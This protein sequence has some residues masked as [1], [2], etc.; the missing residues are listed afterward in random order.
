VLITTR[1]RV[2]VACTG[3]LIAAASCYAETQVQTFDTSWTVSPWDFYGEVSSRM[4][5][6]TPYTIWD[7]TLGSLSKVEISTVVSGSRSK[8]SEAL[9]FAYCFYTGGSDRVDYQFDSGFTFTS[10]S[11]ELHWQ[12]T[13]SLTGNALVDWLTYYYVPKGA[14]TGA[15][16]VETNAPTSTYTI[17][18]KTSLTYEYSPFA[19]TL[20]IDVASGVKNQNQAGRAFLSGT[21]SLVKRGLGTLVLD[22]MNTITGSTTVQGG[23]LRLA[24]AAALPTSTISVLA[25]GTLSLAP[26]LATTVGGLKTNAGGRV[27]VGD[28]SITVAKG[29]SAFSLFSALQAG[30]GSG[31]WNGASG[32]TSSA[33]AASS[34]SRTVGWLDNGDGSVTFGYAAAGD[35][36]LDWT[37]DILDVSGMLSSGRFNSGLTAT[38]AEGDFN[39]DGFADIT[40]V[41]D[42]L[43]T[44]LYDDGFYNAPAGTI[45]AVP[46]PSV[47]GLVGLGAGVVGLMAARRKRAA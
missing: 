37:I 10:G 41:A 3:F 22:Q 29:L 23:V 47:L 26:G 12:E 30:R 4:W 13:R 45:A 18:A 7:S 14:S 42:F 28:G 43:A 5:N 16:Y 17:L 21:Q 20:T 31:S 15:Y 19:S 46:E 27:D 9:T 44:G 32:I 40:D 38:W 36:N 34:G 1:I 8:P 33:A 6:H 25:G 35:T 11:T 2:V 39:Y 24:H